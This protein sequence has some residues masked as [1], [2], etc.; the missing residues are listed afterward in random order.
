M[1]FW[2]IV[3][4]I[5]FIIYLGEMFVVSALGKRHGFSTGRIIFVCLTWP[6]LSVI[7]VSKTLFRKLRK[8]WVGIASGEL[9]GEESLKKPAPTSTARPSKEQFNV[10]T[11]SL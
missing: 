5:L 7:G 9:L 8:A 10:Y 11:E 4:A 2:N 1:G 3:F 6:I